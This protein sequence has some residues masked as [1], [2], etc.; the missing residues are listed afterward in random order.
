MSVT[1]YKDTRMVESTARE[2]ET[3]K[4]HTTKQEPAQEHRP[5]HNRRNQRNPEAS[6]KVILKPQMRITFLL[7]VA[8]SSDSFNRSDTI[9]KCM[10][11]VGISR[12]LSYESSIKPGLVH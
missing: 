5:V 12:L 1:H 11:Q 8:R 6:Q 7:S 4:A 3:T 2:L 10:K 9:G